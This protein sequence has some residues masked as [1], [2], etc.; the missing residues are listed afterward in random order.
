[1]AESRATRT[2]YCPACG[3]ELVDRGFGSHP[4]FCL[5]CLAYRTQ[6]E[7]IRLVIRTRQECLTI[8]IAGPG[9]F[10]RLYVGPLEPGEWELASTPQGQ[11]FVVR[12]ADAS[13]ADAT[14]PPRR[15]GS[16]RR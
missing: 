5:R 13:D 6:R 16:R 7:A 8:P 10:G 12:D 9:G 1:M 15:R 14:R 4:F 11:V 2:A 3:R